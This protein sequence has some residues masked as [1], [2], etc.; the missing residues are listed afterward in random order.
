M[1]NKLMR[2]QD[3]IMA[4]LID[5]HGELNR[6]V[7]EMTARPDRSIMY[8]VRYYSSRMSKLAGIAVALEKMNYPGG[9]R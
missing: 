7:Q 6:A 9:R 4:E 5:T 1:E 3:F 2:A 8:G